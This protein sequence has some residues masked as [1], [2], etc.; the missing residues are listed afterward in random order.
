MPYIKFGEPLHVVNSELIQAKL[1][2]RAYDLC[3]GS[4]FFILHITTEVREL[5]L[6]DRHVLFID[7]LQHKLGHHILKLLALPFT[8]ALQQ[9][10]AHFV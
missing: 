7:M 4:S 10:K 1:F 8:C 6:H 2:T 5:F 9:V 3:Y